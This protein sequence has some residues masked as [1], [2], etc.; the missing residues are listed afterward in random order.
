LLCGLIQVLDRPALEKRSGECYAVV[1]RG[2]DRLLP[3]W[4]AA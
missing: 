3:V 4:L 1:K 2:Y